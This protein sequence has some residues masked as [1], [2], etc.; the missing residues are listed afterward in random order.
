MPRPRGYDA[1]APNFRNRGAAKE[2][3]A[4]SGK[5]Y[6]ILGFH[7]GSAAVLRRVPGTNGAA[8]SF[9]PVKGRG[10]K[11]VLAQLGAKRKGTT[12]D[13]AWSLL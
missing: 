1:A 6:L 5:G 10:Q 3:I 9:K 2:F 4:K 11:D 13:M 8:A 12:Y 7:D